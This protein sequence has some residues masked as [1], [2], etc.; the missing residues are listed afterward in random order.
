[1][2]V[3]VIIPAFN[4]A[5]TIREILRRVQETPF[6]KEI[7]VVDDGSTD[8]TG[9]AL[10]TVD[11]RNLRVIAHEK[12]RGKGAAVRTG[13]AAATGDYVILQDADL[14]YDPRDYARLLEPLIEGDAD[15]VYGSRFV[16]SP[17]RVLLFWHTVGNHVLTLLSNM[18]TNLNLTDM[19]TGYKAFRIDVVRRLSLNSERF[20]IE[21]ELTAKV[22]KL[23]C[24]VYEVPVS[25]HGRTY[26]EGKK[27]RWTDGISAAGAILRYGLF[28]GRTTAHVGLET[29]S[30]VTALGH[31]N[32]WL[33]ERVAGFIGERVF[34]AG[35]GTGTITHYLAGR[36]RV[37]C[38]DVDEQYV[39]MLQR[40]YANRPNIRVE[41]ADL[42]STTWPVLDGERIDTV[43]CMN[44]LEHLPDDQY[45]LQRFR[46]ILEPGGRLVLLVPAHGWLYGS[47]DVA[48]GHHRR[49][50]A[51]PLRSLCERCGFTVE[52][53]EYINPTGVVGWLLNGRVF[54]REEVPDRQ[55]RVYDALFPVLRRAQALSLP[56]GLS[57]LV[58]ARKP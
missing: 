27:I 25:Y 47:M 51:G 30:T 19:E 18:V 48:L 52:R 41:W 54:R 24:R 43:V 15:V 5:A 42:S 16:G 2:K 32:T 55:A 17:R 33:W 39:A 7:I 12:N 46:S 45:V 37:V 26:E 36:Q 56:L 4:E 21:P 23:R 1:M 34:E 50:E 9:E 28:T 6:D 22:A 57:L 44:V 49:Y 11:R 38:A 20:G 14:E 53:S 8:G 3:S 35:C 10:A 29:L 58:V 40:R 13:F 31:Y